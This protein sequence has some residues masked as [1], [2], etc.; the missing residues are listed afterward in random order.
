ML[1]TVTPV[2]EFSPACTP[3]TFRVR[4][5][6]GPRTLLGSVVGTDMDCPNDGI[7]YYT[8]G[9]SATFAVDRLSGTSSP[10][11]GHRGGARADCG[12]RLLRFPFLGEVRLLGP[13]D[14]EQRRLYRLTVLVS[15]QSGDQASAR[16]RS[17]S[18]TITI[19]VEVIEPQGLGENWKEFRSPSRILIFPLCLSFFRWL[20]GVG[21]A[22]G[23]K[24]CSLW[25][26]S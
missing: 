25:P 9:G 2:N 1:V 11:L 18:C 4:E 14:Y 10:G 15:D 12:L 19:E 7:E 16:H 23:G 5:D 20:A 3:R 24:L 21:G 13:L 8:S 26:D 22:S 6:A 17:G